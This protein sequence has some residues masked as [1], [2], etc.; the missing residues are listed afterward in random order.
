MPQAPVAD[1]EKYVDVEDALNRICNNKMIYKKLLGTFKTSLQYDQLCGE[2][3]AGDMETAVRTAHSIKGVTAN[4]SLKA[5][6]EKSVIVEAGLKE[7]RVDE[8]ELKELGDV[9]ATTVLCTDYLIETL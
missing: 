4:L 2:I 5:A 9:L 3:A 8:N 6:Y 7:G 1:M